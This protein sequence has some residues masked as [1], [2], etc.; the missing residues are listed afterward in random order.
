MWCLLDELRNNVKSQEACSEIR[1]QV[2]L[3]E[4]NIFPPSEEGKK[5]LER[6]L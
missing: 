2:L 4:V 1:T 3:F 6:S 5:A